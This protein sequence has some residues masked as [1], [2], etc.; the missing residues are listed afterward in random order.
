MPKPEIVKEIRGKSDIKSPYRVRRLIGEALD[1]FKLN[2]KGLTVLT[3]AASGSYTFTP[4]I[5]ALAGAGKVH[6]VTKDS[7]YASAEQVIR[8]TSL[9]ADYCGIGARL[10]THTL[11]TPEIIGEADIVTNL[12][13]VRPINKEFISHMQETAVIPLMCEPWEYREEELDLA[14]CWQKGIAVLGT[15][16]K[17]K[18]LEAFGYIGYLAM[19]LAFELDIEVFK[20]KV[21]VVGG[22]YFGKNTVNAFTNAGGK[23]VNFRITDN[24]RL[25]SERAKSELADCDLLVFVEHQSRDLILGEDG[26]LTVSELLSINPGISIVHIAG[27][28]EKEAIQK[29]QIPYR[30]SQLAPPGYMSVTIGYLGPRSIIDLCAAGLKV[31]EAMARGML[32]YNNA[33]K[34]KRYALKNSPAIDFKRHNE[35]NIPRN[36]ETGLLR[37]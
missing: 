28:V 15:D 17:A 1:K 33:D 8:N 19:K 25:S 4:I 37:T 16:E 27:G 5:A 2:L 32:R 35:G 22:G 24:E 14:E 11:L 10:E 21:V 23:V 6:A 29:A 3:E 13:F 12:G 34:A 31:G 36:K 30:P 20:S 18:E 26:Q 7:Q 9:L